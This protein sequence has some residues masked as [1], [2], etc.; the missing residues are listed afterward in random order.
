MAGHV[1]R[2]QL[3]GGAVALIALTT[4]MIAAP[5]YAAPI[6]SLLAPA[7]SSAPV[8]LMAYGADTAANAANAAAS[9]ATDAASSYSSFLSALPSLPPVIAGLNVPGVFDVFSN[10]TGFLPWD[11]SFGLTIGNAGGLGIEGWAPTNPLFDLV[12]ES[13]GTTTG[14]WP[15]M[16]SLIGIETLLGGF[17]NTESY[18]NFFDPTATTC[19]ICDTFSLLGPNNT[20]LFSWTTNIPIGGLPQF[21]LSTPLGNLARPWETRS[22]TARSQTVS[23]ATRRQCC[24]AWPAR[25]RSWSTISPA[26][27]RRA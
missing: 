11:Y 9:A 25:Q 21:E 26:R 14:A 16:A 5:A 24:R 4:T 15:G 13:V 12:A 18:A 20:D 10:L 7:T 2:Q 19:L 22:T 3:A 8:A 6:D 23:S 1:L 17:T 27:S